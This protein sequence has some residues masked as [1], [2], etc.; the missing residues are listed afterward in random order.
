MNQNQQQ[1][2]SDQ[3]CK[4]Q[5]DKKLIAFYDR[6]R[7]ASITNYA[8]LH[9]KGEYKESDHKTHSLIGVTIQDYSNGTGADTVHF[10]TNHCRLS[11]I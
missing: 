6:L 11:G 7:Y 9:A 2:I 10:N 8:Q 1:R 5:T 3:I 4:V